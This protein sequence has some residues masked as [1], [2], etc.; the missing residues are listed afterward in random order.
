MLRI[1][2]ALLLIISSLSLPV[3][4]DQDASSKPLELSPDAPSRHVVVSGDTLWGIASTFLK[5]PYRWNELWRNNEAGIRNPNLIYPGQVL[6]LD[7]S[8]A[9]PVLRLANGSSAAAEGGGTFTTVKVLPQIRIEEAEKAIPAIPQDVI[10]PFL[11]QPLVADSAVLGDAPRIIGI[12]EDRVMAGS[13]DV[14]YAVGGPVKKKFWQVFRSGKAL[15]DPESG[16]NLGYEAVLLG[17]ATLV[18]E[19]ETS[20]FQI[21]NAKQEIGRDDRLLPAPNPDILTYP[22]RLPERKI[23]GRVIAIYG[24]GLAGSTYSIVALSRGRNDGLEVGHVLALFTSAREVSNGLDS[25]TLP[26]ERKGLMYVFRVFDRVSYALVM[27]SSS[28]VMAGDAV[29]NP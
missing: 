15:I 20:S 7:R 28:Q 29:R 1:I 18:K 22:Q 21:S 19:G 6:V 26:E 9:S 24:S 12:K 2:S 16:D 14:V 27:K 23:N 5:D 25:F 11:T 10:E 17:T 13:G 8:G 3:H 4:A